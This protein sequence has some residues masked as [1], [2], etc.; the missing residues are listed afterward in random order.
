MKSERIEFLPLE[1]WYSR[2]TLYYKRGMSVLNKFKKLREF[3]I[4]GT[5]LIIREGRLSGKVSWNLN[6]VLTEI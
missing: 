5:N 2:Q 4:G 3:K 1:S 6:G